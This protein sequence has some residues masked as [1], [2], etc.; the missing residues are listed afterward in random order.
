MSVPVVAPVVEAPVVD[1]VS[2]LEVVPDMEPDIEPDAP[3]VAEPVEVVGA[4]VLL[5]APAVVSLTAPL[6]EP[7][8][9]VDW[10]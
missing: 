6:A 9:E 3:V 5:E 7:E 8:A 1:V 10:A 4:A 2:V